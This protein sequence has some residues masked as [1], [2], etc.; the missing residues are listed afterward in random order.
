LERDQREI[1]GE[2]GE[3][4]ERDHRE[5]EEILESD[6]RLVVYQY[7]YNKSARRRRGTKGGKKHIKLI[8]EIG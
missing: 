8:T 4:S 7:A 1:G 6:R 2:N 3:R 5:I